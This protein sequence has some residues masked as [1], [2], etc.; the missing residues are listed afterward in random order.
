MNNATKFIITVLI[1]ALGVLAINTYQSGGF[2][3]FKADTTPTQE[4][5]VEE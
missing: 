4:V 2:E 3:N 1:M 5:N